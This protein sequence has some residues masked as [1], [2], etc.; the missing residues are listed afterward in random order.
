MLVVTII[1]LFSLCL[2]W[3]TQAAPMPRMPSSYP[4]LKNQLYKSIMSQALSQQE[5]SPSTTDKDKEMAATFCRLL[6][7]TLQSISEK[8]VDGPVDDYCKDIELPPEPRPEERNSK[9]AE[10]YQKIFDTLKS[11]SG[12]NGYPI[13]FWNNFSG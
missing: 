7:Q 6:L 8:F 12:S 10:A 1:A 2:P 11:I 9:L 4:G 13:K 3:E 5:A